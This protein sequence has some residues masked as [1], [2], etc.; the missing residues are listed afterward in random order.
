MDE[1]QKETKSLLEAATA[2]CK[3]LREELKKERMMA[4]DA[5]SVADERASVS[6]KVVSEVEKS[7]ADTQ[8][9]LCDVRTDLEDV[10]TALADR[11]AGFCVV[12]SELEGTRKSLADAQ[13][14]ACD[15]RKELE[16]AHQ[17][18]LFLSGQV[19]KIGSKSCFDCSQFKARIAE[20][21][22]IHKQTGQELEKRTEE[23]RLTRESVK[24][25]LELREA[26]IEKLHDT[27]S[28]FLEKLYKCEARVQELEDKLTQYRQGGGAIHRLEQKLGRRDAAILQYQ[29]VLD[30]NR[31]LIRDEGSPERKQRWKIEER[32]TIAECNVKAL[33]SENERM[34]EQIAKFEEREKSY[35]LETQKL[36]REIKLR[37]LASLKSRGARHREALSEKNES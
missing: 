25:D 22:S 15:A 4:T 23:V 27:S 18:S 37:D 7:L 26:E 14:M 34:L 24:R 20:L 16:E 3:S 36:R 10:R 21:E 5:L 19:D 32:A 31:K 1:I 33:S 35:Q 8:A 2:E 28:A 13:A 30:A 6:E 12:E 9:E 17:R 11:Q 29:S